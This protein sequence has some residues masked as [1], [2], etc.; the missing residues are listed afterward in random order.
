MILL[1]LKETNFKKS[2]R[3]ES[4]SSKFKDTASHLKFDKSKNEAKILNYCNRDDILL[5]LDELLVIEYYSRR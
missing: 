3:R 4:K 5:E 2:S 1:E